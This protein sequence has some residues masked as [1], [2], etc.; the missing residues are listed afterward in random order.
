MLVDIA[1]KDGSCLDDL[2]V[3]LIWARPYGP[4]PIVALPVMDLALPIPP[5]FDDLPVSIAEF[6]LLSP[7]LLRLFMTLSAPSV[8]SRNYSTVYWA[9]FSSISTS[10]SSWVLSVC[11]LSKL[12]ITLSFPFF[13]PYY[14]CDFSFS[15]SCMTYIPS[16]MLSSYVPVILDEFKLPSRFYLF[17]PALASARLLGE[18]LT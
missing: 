15:S 10:P 5:A 13:L 18:T 6:F 7:V 16:C 14:L 12:I 9:I 4:E 1:C 2:W 11:K 17:L 3:E 8:G